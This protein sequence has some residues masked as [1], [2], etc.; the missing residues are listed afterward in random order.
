MKSRCTSVLCFNVAS[1]IVWSCCE[2]FWRTAERKLQRVFIWRHGEGEVVGGVGRKVRSH[3]MKA[4]LSQ[5]ETGVDCEASL[6]IVR[7]KVFGERWTDRQ[8]GTRG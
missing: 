7:E 3:K 5:E 1:P 8:S 2:A 6:S 4:R